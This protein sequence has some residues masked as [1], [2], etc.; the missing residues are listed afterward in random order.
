MDNKSGT[1]NKYGPN[2]NKS[3]VT[4]C[5]GSVSIEMGTYVVAIVLCVDYMLEGINFL[6]GDPQN[7]VFAVIFLGLG[8]VC[9]LVVFA[10][11]A[12]NL[13]LFVPY[14][15]AGVHFLLRVDRGS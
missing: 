5:C 10:Q 3:G 6:I 1:T 15:I 4:C 7:T 14:L 12:R 2:N 13:W 9:S 8:C 11:H